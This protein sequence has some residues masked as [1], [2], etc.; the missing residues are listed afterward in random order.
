MAH[1]FHTLTNE[2]IDHIVSEVKQKS[3]ILDT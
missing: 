2:D 1:N 3:S